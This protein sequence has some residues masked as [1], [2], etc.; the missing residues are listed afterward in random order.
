MENNHL[1][2]FQ[3][4]LDYWK[5]AKLIDLEDSYQENYLDGYLKDYYEHYCAKHFFLPP[6]AED[7][8][9]EDIYIL[10]KLFISYWE[11]QKLN[12]NNDPEYDGIFSIEN[13]KI[14]QS[15]CA[16]HINVCKDFLLKLDYD[17]EI[18]INPD[19]REG[20]YFMQWI[21]KK[22]AKFNRAERV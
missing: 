11:K 12:T 1:V 17:A 14:L 5:K 20:Y 4:F 9:I 19:E 2:F 8:A 13:D 21:S 22:W 15:E 7:Y 18:E 6:N 10:I 3:S 16:T